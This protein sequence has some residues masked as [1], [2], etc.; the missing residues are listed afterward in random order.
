MP[1]LTHLKPGDYL[2]TDNREYGSTPG[3][4]R[5]SQT[6]WLIERETSTQLHAVSSGRPITVRKSDGKVIGQNYASAVEATMEMREK[7]RAQVATLLRYRQANALV[8]DLLG[9]ELHQLKLTTEQLEALADAWLKIKAMATTTPT[10]G[11]QNGNT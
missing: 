7:H 9:K 8:N 6:I 4:P 3:R 11:E 2:A 1:N 10:T 5:V